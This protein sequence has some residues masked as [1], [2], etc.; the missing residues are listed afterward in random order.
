VKE[1]LKESI[2]ENLIWNLY[3]VIPV[4][5]FVIFDYYYFDDFTTSHLID[6]LIGLANSAGLF[7]IIL[8]LGYGLIKIPLKY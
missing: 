2:K 1:K 4:L 5:I 6:I 7:Y 8:L 3:L